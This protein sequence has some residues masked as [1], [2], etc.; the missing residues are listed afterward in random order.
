M[1]YSVDIRNN[2]TGE[3]RTCS[4]RDLAWNDS[5]VFWWTEGNMSCDCNRELEFV[6][7]GGPGP[8][9][10]P[11]WN[12]LDTECGFERFTVIRAIL[13]DGTVVPIDDTQESV[14]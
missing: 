1:K 2:A 11:R 8:D 10:D 12:D 5:S 7:A 9:D 6:R 3:V 4:Q 13:E 14:K